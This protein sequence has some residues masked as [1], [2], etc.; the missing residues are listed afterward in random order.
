MC[1]DYPLLNGLTIKNKYAIP[2]VEE[3]L[4]KYHGATI[5]SKL[6]CG[7]V[8]AKKM[9][10]KQQQIHTKQ[11]NTPRVFEFLVMPLGYP[12]HQPPLR[13][14]ILVFFFLRYSNLIYNKDT[15]THTEHLRTALTIF[16][17]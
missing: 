7:L 15:Q 6:D 13:K 2:V 14:F 12:M 17:Q 4:D 11:N 16:R 8:S 1:I 3:L 10:T 5:F 9:H